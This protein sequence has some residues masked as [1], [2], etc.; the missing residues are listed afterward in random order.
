[1]LIEHGFSSSAPVGSGQ[2]PCRRQRT[3]LVFLDAEITAQGE[4]WPDRLRAES[5]F[6]Q[7]LHEI[8][9]LVVKSGPE[10]TG[11]SLSS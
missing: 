9:A 5:V 7:N 11:K 6:C 1:M 2:R 10:T 4:I 8:S 3:L